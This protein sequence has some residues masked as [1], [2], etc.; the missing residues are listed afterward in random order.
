MERPPEAR[1]RRLG[2]PPHGGHI[3]GSGGGDGIAESGSSPAADG[4]R[5]ERARSDA[6]GR[7]RSKKARSRSRLGRAAPRRPRAPRRGWRS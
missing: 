7:V 4:Q 5:R 1:R 3:G 6:S 2:D